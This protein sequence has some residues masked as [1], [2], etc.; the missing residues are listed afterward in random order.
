MFHAFLS[1]SHAA[2]GP[3]AS[4]LQSALHRFAKPWYRVRAVRIF[5]DQTSL[6]ANPGLW[7][8]IE[9]ALTESQHFILLA[10]PESARSPWVEREV[11]WWMANK[12]A[13]SIIIAVTDGELAWDASA[14]DFDWRRT[15]V[16]PPSLRGRLP[17][18]PLYVDLRWARSEHRLSLANE[19][20]RGAVLDVAAVLRGTPKDELG[21][22]EIRQHRRTLS[23]AWGAVIVFATLAL[24]AGALAW[25]AYRRGNEIERQARVVL[26]RQLSAQAELAR[27]ERVSLL[28]LGVLLTINSLRLSP[29]LE[30]YE[31]LRY[32][33]ALL[34]RPIS[35]HQLGGG[36]VGLSADGR[37]VALGSR[38]EVRIWAL[39]GGGGSVPGP[40]RYRGSLRRLGLSADARYLAARVAADDQSSHTSTQLWD[41]STGETVG[42]IVE[43]AKACASH[44][45]V[46][47]SR[48]AGVVAM[49]SDD[50]VVV[51]RTDR[52]PH[53]PTVLP[54]PGCVTALA[55]SADDRLL[56]TATLDGIV[57]I[58][59]L[60]GNEIPSILRLTDRNR[61]EVM[62]LAFSPDGRYLATGSP[63]RTA[64]V[65]SLRTG[66]EIVRFAHGQWVGT[67][68]FSPDGARLATGSWDRT[69]RVWD[70]DTEREVV[71]V[72]HE[73]LV[74]GVAFGADGRSLTSASTDGAVRIHA[75]DFPAPP[76][77]ARLVH[78][79]FR[80]PIGLASSGDGR[81]L[82]IADGG[83]VQI[84]KGG[85]PEPVYRGPGTAVAFAADGGRFATVSSGEGIR[86][87]ELEP[88]VRH[89]MTLPHDQR[90]DVL[91]MSPDG[92]H[93]LAGDQRGAHLWQLS[94]A[95]VAHT[96][97]PVVAA[98][99]VDRGKTLLTLNGAGA[100][101]TVDVASGRI[102][103]RSWSVPTSARPMRRRFSS[104]GR[105][106]ATARQDG[107]VAVWDTSAGRQLASLGPFGKSSGRGPF[108]PV[109]AF[110]G[111]GAHLVVG[112]E[113]IRPG[114]G[115][116]VH[117]WELS[118]GREV[119]RFVHP[120]TVWDV[121]F[122]G[123]DRH[124]ATVGFESASLWLWRTDDL[125]AEACARVPR[126]T[127]TAD[128]QRAYFGDRRPEETCSEG[129]RR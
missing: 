36:T 69:A 68:V 116:T 60:A 118:T 78:G 18:E 84:W 70:I 122:S 74:V 28:P 17:A 75:W 5:R 72:S 92:E 7:D 82:A 55:F 52:E 65:W 117:V 108:A 27:T 46:A 50:G 59:N 106:L 125:I 85:G 105:L 33:I 119:A 111:D 129:D 22:E 115:N 51:S 67:V 1:Y 11:A 112:S 127:F 89:A 62:N 81:Y 64:R 39:T 26:A 63:D 120:E 88:E 98:A 87:W 15:T 43:A 100:L 77:R 56:A 103:R 9:R 29:S 94:S 48:A 91:V 13:T 14:G 20:F 42:P 83:E 16:L 54:H 40:I 8:A 128:E 102:E 47:F 96:L 45:A 109:I 126:K 80:A 114:E 124:V 2:D 24:V 6:A 104:D 21:G 3:V 97:P 121:A 71:R 49:A 38:G 76:E 66:R 23:I 35:D 73:A 4:A 93:L 37:H 57:R 123:D 101:D 53:P 95:R 12:S 32:G 99:F 31:F 10:S 61:Y 25:V 19:R 44:A 86:I 79:G 110:S 58:W 113:P 34:P 30:A 107:S 41:L 90:I